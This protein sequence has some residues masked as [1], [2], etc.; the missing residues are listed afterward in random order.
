MDQPEHE[1]THLLAEI[2][3][4]SDTARE[5]LWNLVYQRLREIAS[6][7]VRREKNPDL[8]TTT[9]LVHE[10]YLKIGESSTSHMEN[11]NHFFS[12][13]ANA[14][15]QVLVDAARKRLSQKREIGDLKPSLH[16][17]DP[18]Q[19]LQV[20]ALLD[21]LAQQHP[22]LAHI[23]EWRFFGGFDQKTIAQCL[24]VSVKTVERDWQRAKAYLQWS[25]EAPSPIPMAGEKA[26]E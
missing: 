26:G 8:L 2:R 22:R 12:I 18:Q 24:G 9:G 3:A 14:M 25:F 11:R 4:G 6:S 5:E 17:P 1:I 19:V 23:V 20:H 15:R 10:A 7:Q 13:A 16:E 21:A